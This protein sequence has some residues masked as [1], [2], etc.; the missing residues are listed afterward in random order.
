MGVELSQYGTFG[1]MAA[2]E[3]IHVLENHQYDLHGESHDLWSDADA[4]A[5][6]ARTSCVREQATQFVV[7]N[8]HF[9]GN[10]TWHYACVHGDGA[11][12]R[13]S[14]PGAR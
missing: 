4:A 8:T 3:L 12:A 14:S 11:S 13:H 6:E 1:T 9:D 7:D 2:H 5:H 10:L